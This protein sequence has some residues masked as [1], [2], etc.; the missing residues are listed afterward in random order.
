MRLRGSRRTTSLVEQGISGSRAERSDRRENT[1][2]KREHPTY[3]FTGQKTSYKMSCSFSTAS[4]LMVVT[5]VYPREIGTALTVPCAIPRASSVLEIFLK[6]EPKAIGGEPSVCKMSNSVSANNGFVVITQVHPQQSST[7][8]TSPST[9]SNVSSLLGKFLKGEPKALGAVQ[10]MIGVMYILCGIAINIYPDSIGVFSGIVY[11]GAFIYISSG[12]LSVAGENK[13]NK[14]VV[15]GSLG[16]NI[17]STITAGIAVILFSVDL[18]VEMGYY[19]CNSYDCS[20]IEY[21]YTTRSRG[22][23]GMLLVFSILEFIISIYVS[24]FACRAVCD[25]ALEHAVFIQNP[26]TSINT[27]TPGYLPGPGVHIYDTVHVSGMG[28]TVLNN[29]APVKTNNETE[30]SKLY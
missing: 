22:I 5:Q 24:T 27:V 11:W 8:L 10:I 7:A 13:L 2:N 20:R 3:P 14:C 17:I 19:Y 28:Q 29:C 21:I 15:K 26:Q 1:R 18:V 6:C 4:G 30:P 25:P 12:A 23:S 16:M 9:A